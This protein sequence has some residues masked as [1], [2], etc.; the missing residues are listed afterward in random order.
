MA[1]GR[2]SIK[3]L[4]YSSPQCRQPTEAQGVIGSYGTDRPRVG[5][6][7]SDKKQAG[8]APP[9]C[10]LKQLAAQLE[11]FAAHRLASK[12]FKRQPVYRPHEFL[13]HRFELCHQG[14]GLFESVLSRIV[15]EF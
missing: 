5:R 13:S 12:R 15:F 1:L 7:P 11:A 3:Q 2:H 10:P 9:I 6:D 14:A 8:Q 4:S